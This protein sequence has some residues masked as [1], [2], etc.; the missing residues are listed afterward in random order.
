MRAGGDAQAP[1]FV[2][3]PMYEGFDV[4]RRIATETLTHSRFRAIESR[5]A[6]V[7]VSEGG[8]TAMIN[9]SGEVLRLASGPSQ[10][11]SILIAHVPVDH[12]GTLYVL[13]GD[14][15]AAGACIVLAVGA[16]ARVAGTGQ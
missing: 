14:S 7:R 11:Q 16:L 6:Q 4:D 3:V 2:V 15:L 13:W 5:R 8:Y 9:G 10:D 1:D 12:R